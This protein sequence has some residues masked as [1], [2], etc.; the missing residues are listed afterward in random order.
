M[1]FHILQ[2]PDLRVGL[3]KEPYIRVNTRKL[4]RELC[5]SLFTLYTLD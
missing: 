3:V 4:D 2:S 5:T 1:Q